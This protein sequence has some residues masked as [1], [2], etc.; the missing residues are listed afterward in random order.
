MPCTDNALGDLFD[1]VFD[2]APPFPGRP[3]IPFASG[4]L[5]IVVA[6]GGC[7]SV[8]SEMLSGLGFF[9]RDILAPDALSPVLVPNG[10][11]APAFV[12]VVVVTGTTAGV[13]DEAVLVAP[14]TVVF[15]VTGTLA[16]PVDEVVSDAAT[17]AAAAADAVAEVAAGT[18]VIAAVFG[19]AIGAAADAPDAVFE[20][21]VD[22]FDAVFVVPDASAAIAIA[23][24]EVTAA[25][26]PGSSHSSGSSQPP[27]SSCNVPRS[28]NASFRTSPDE[29]ILL[30]IPPRI[31]ESRSRTSSDANRLRP[32]LFFVIFFI[33]KSVFIFFSCS[34]RASEK[35]LSWFSSKSSP[36]CSSSSFSSF[37]ERTSPGSKLGISSFLTEVKGQ[38]T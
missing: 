1:V 21:L 7:L 23:T 12:V 2:L 15:V 8:T 31:S 35:L 17:G 3:W 9:G 16:G 5:V 25:S 14:A 38:F 4:P 22:A 6:A 19:F 18:P 30:F 26:T 36:K 37:E 29:A 24:P 10:A 27:S 32:P 33:V 11:V 28:I 13:M 20:V 34:S